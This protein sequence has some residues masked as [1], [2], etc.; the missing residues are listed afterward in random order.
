MAYSILK[1][2]ASVDVLSPA[3]APLEPLSTFAETNPSTHLLDTF[4]KRDVSEQSDSSVHEFASRALQTGAIPNS[5]NLSGA[6]PGIVVGATL[7]AVA[8]VIFLFWLISLLMGAQGMGFI[9]GSD[10][11]DVHVHRRA[12]SEPRSRRTRRTRT[13]RSDMSERS[14][15]PRR[16]ERILVEETRR[17]ERSRPPPPEEPLSPEVEREHVEVEE[18]EAERRVEGDDVVEVIEEQSDITPDPPRRKKSGYRP[19][20]PDQYGGGNYA[21]REVYENDRRRRRHR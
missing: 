1:P 13:H 10:V 8:G 18:R 14:S 3:L 5:Y 11:T 17:T 4:S 21:Q 16:R 9:E 2:R 15:P 7:G 19:V 6:K 12:Y 20:D